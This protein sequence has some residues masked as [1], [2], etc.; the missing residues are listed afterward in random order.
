MQNARLKALSNGHVRK[1][2]QQTNASSA[3]RQEKELREERQRRIDEEYE[4]RLAAERKA[5]IDRAE[6]E[7]YDNTD[8]VRLSSP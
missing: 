7:V 1:W 4:A 8:E 2:E 3:A 5:M 6:R